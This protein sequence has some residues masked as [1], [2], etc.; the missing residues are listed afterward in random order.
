M[1]D[2]RRAYN[3]L[4]GYV[5]REWD[6][7]KDLELMKAW[8]ELNEANPG[9]AKTT[10][11]TGKTESV[12]AE[13]GGP[14]IEVP[15]GTDIKDAARTIL[16]VDKSADFK[17]IRRAFEKLNRRAQPE[18][19]EPGTQEASNAENLQRKVQWA[20]AVLTAE[21]SDAEKRFRSLEID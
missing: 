14:K 15:K 12:E 10:A 9:G 19:F 1:N 7:I 16:G 17:E 13:P 11:G 20:Y 4:R 21:V 5:N 18:N 6:R 2:A 8:D 3:L